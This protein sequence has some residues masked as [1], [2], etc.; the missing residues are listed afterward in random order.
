MT[1]WGHPKRGFEELFFEKRFR[2]VIFRLLSQMLS[3]DPSAYVYTDAG[4]SRIGGHRLFRGRKA[5]DRNKS[6][7]IRREQ[8]M[9]VRN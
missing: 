3:V 2:R 6:K 7:K 1:F 5:V 9:N 4:G 8:G